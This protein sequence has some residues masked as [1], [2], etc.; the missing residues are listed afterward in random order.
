MIDEYGTVEE[1]RIPRAAEL[2]RE[3]LLQCHVL[4]HNSVVICHEIEPRAA[5][6]LTD[7][8]LSQL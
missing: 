4:N 5:A 7:V 6:M 3:K 1:M 8:Y 2:L